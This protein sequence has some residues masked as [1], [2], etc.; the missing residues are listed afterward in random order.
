MPSVRLAGRARGVVVLS[1]LSDLLVGG[2]VGFELGHQLVDE[3]ADLVRARAEDREVAA[4]RV[5]DVLR[6]HEFGV[7]EV[8]CGDTFGE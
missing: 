4:G 3:V 5:L 6:S 2:D 1:A 8:Q 7:G